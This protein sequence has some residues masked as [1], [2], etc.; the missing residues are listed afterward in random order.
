MGRQ[1][2]NFIYR[3]IAAVF[4][5]LGL[6]PQKRARRMADAIG[7][8]WF[9][10]DRRHR[11]V[12]IENL[13]LAF[14]AEKSRAEIRDLAH[15]IFQ[16]LA[17]ILFEIGWARHLPERKFR[18]YF[19]FYGL[20]HLL[21]ASRKNKGVLVLT[22]HMGNWELMAMAAGRLGY[23]MSG[24]YRPLDFK[25]L[26]RY[27]MD[28]R[29]AY[30]AKLY[31]KAN[32]MRKI[33]RSL[34]Q[35]ELVGI[36]LDQNTNVQSGVFVEFFGRTA[37]TNKGLALLA[38]GTRTPVVPLFVL[39]EKTG[40]R[41]DIGPEIPLLETGDREEDIRINTRLYN[42]A[43]EAVIRRYPEQWFWVHRRWKTRPPEPTES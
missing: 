11:K 33:L 42:R 6:L 21:A 15:S 8:A 10:L 13:T 28:L 18:K 25:P 27:F 9:V 29:A 36:L 43:L 4:R 2:D 14:G 7:H 12:A 34:K 19:R 38:V 26:D 22:A 1:L 41:V 24:V 17:L 35:K 5:L 30:G 39:R 40:F 16:N 3:M 31:P 20:H 32:A 23:S 37:C